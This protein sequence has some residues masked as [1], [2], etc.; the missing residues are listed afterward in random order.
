M[1]NVPNGPRQQHA[2]YC[3]HVPV[4]H[5]E[6]SH[7][8]AKNQQSFQDELVSITATTSLQQSQCW[9]L[10]P[11]PTL[12]VHFPLATCDCAWADTLRCGM[13]ASLSL[14]PGVCNLGSSPNSGARKCPT[15]PIGGVPTL[16]H[17]YLLL[18]EM[19]KPSPHDCLPPSHV[20]NSP[21]PIYHLAHPLAHS[22]VIIIGKSVT[23]IMLLA[24]VCYV[25]LQPHHYYSRQH[26]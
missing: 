17:Q 7:H 13:E 23:A 18:Q 4:C 15:Q 14:S 10:T 16:A 8:E 21:P 12:P 9:R 24:L 22:C 25:M 20:P 11:A 19:H 2:Q 6:R 3:S 1:I 26:F 5:A